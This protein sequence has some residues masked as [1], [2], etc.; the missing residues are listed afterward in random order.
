MSLSSLFQD[1]LE[2]KD[3][4]DALS[5]LNEKGREKI[6]QLREELESMEVYGKETCD[7]KY[8]VE[9]EAQKHQLVL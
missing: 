7:D 5:E 3:S 9:M 4:M 6:S 2:C 8:S 1:I